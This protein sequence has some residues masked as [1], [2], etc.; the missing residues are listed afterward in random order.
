MVNIGPVEPRTSTRSLIYQ[1]NNLTLTW[2]RTQPSATRLVN[3]C[4]VM[5]LICQSLM[6][7]QYLQIEKHF[8]SFS[9]HSPVRT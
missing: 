6:S 2:L 8:E 4:R 3:E 1:L 7:C 5:T 9:A